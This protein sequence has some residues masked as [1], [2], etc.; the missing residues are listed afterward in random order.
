MKFAEIKELAV[1]ELNKKLKTLREEYFELRM[2][3]SLGQAGNPLMIRDVRRNIARVKTSLA[4]K[5]AE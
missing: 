4:Q 3:N 5:L 1:D 2:K